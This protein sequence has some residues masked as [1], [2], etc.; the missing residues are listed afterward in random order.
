[1]VTHRPVLRDLAAATSSASR[2]CAAAARKPDTFS[3]CTS[4][5]LQRLQLPANWRQSAAADRRCLG[6]FVLF[7]LYLLLPRPAGRFLRTLPAAALTDTFSNVGDRTDSSSDLSVVVIDPDRRKPFV[8]SQA[9]ADTCLASSVTATCSVCSLRLHRSGL[10]RIKG[11]NGVST[12]QCS[13]TE[14]SSKACYQS[15]TRNRPKVLMGRLGLWMICKLSEQ[16]LLMGLMRSAA[17]H[18]VKR[19]AACNVH[20]ASTDATGFF[21]WAEGLAS[22]TCARSQA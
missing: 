12:S 2:L 10:P 20:M 3:S 19:L 6:S 8:E 21:Q 9:C 15:K 22:L 1:M 17:K 18:H 11:R 7:Q 14:P 5:A 16:R 13:N 4:K